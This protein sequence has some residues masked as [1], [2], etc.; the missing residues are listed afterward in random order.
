MT[1]FLSDAR[2]RTSQ[3]A[4]IG[5]LDYDGGVKQSQ[6]LHPLALQGTALRPEAL[7]GFAGLP[8]TCIEWVDCVDSTNRVMMDLPLALSAPEQ[9]RLMLAA[10]QTAGRGRRGRSW[11]GEAPACL[12]MS[13]C[14]HRPLIPGR[15]PPVGLPIA[16]GVAVARMLAAETD[17]IGLKWPN[18]LQRAGRKIAGMLVEARHVADRERIVIGLGLNWSQPDGVGDLLPGAGGLFESLPELSVRERI[19]GCLARAM[20]D[21]SIAFFADGLEPS[22]RNWSE[23]DVMHGREVLVFEGRNDPWSGIADGLVADGSLRVRCGDQVRLV[24]S[25]DVSVR[26]AATPRLNIAGVMN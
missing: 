17:Q 13:V 19:A 2:G 22:L 4:V 1:D 12:A 25:G 7:A 5:S 16:L 23:F 26:D 11:L 9:P 18:D 21:A 15:Q 8:I 14:L 20:I 3:I 6:H 10:R 24:A